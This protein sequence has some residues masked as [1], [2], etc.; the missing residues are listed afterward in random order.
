MESDP[1]ETRQY[2]LVAG[3]FQQ[4]QVLMHRFL[5]NEPFQGP[6]VQ[7]YIKN[8]CV[9]RNLLQVPVIKD[10]SRDKIGVRRRKDA[11]TCSML[12][13]IIEESMRVFWDFLRSDKD[14][15]T[16]IWKGLLSSHV[17]LQDP[18]D[19]ELLLQVQTI[20]QKKERKLKDILRSG[21]CI[22]KK[23]QKSHEERSDQLVFFSQVD[24]K[25]VW[26]V[27]NMS[28]LT[29]EQLVWCHKKLSKINFVHRKIHVE[30]SFLPFPC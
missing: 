15:N 23:F 4:F 28:R 6:R 19:S 9:L 17:E 27:L 10:D 21:N 3:E 22:V 16:A 7:H 12:L 18:A 2:N 29:A 14:D 24:L 13:V 8:R 26:R 25:L 11:I 1:Y 20:L 30:P 5:E